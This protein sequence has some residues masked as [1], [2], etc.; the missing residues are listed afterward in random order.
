MNLGWHAARQE[1]CDAVRS[2]VREALAGG[3]CGNMRLVC[4]AVEHDRMH[5]E[6]LSYMVTQQV[7]SQLSVVLSAPNMTV[8]D[9]PRTLC[10][11]HSYACQKMHYDNLLTPPSRQLDNLSCAACPGEGGLRQQARGAADAA[12][13]PGH[14]ARAGVCGLHEPRRRSRCKHSLSPSYS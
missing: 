9:Q 12:S 7:T 8:H 3:P 1:Y 13:E 11:L 14:D 2:L 10:C 5:Q 4:L 6:T